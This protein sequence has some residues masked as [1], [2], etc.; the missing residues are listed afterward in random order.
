M[1]STRESVQHLDQDNMQAAMNTLG[2]FTRGFQAMAAELVDYNKATFEQGTAF[3][4]TLAQAK[5]VGEAFR[6]QSNYLKSSYDNFASE[7]EKLSG[8]WKDVALEATKSSG[9]RATVQ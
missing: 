7:M 8:I 1:A 6:I 2:L 4:Q 9:P 3:F 5:D